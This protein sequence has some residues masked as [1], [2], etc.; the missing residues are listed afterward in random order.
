MRAV[1]TSNV[2]RAFAIGAV[3]L[4]HTT[5][6][7][8]GGGLNLLFLL[9]GMAFAELVFAR[10]EKPAWEIGRDFVARLLLGS[11]FLCLFWFAY[12]RTFEP[13]ELLMFS[14]WITVE[15][16]PLFP[17]WF[18]QT[19]LQ[20]M[21][22]VV[23]LFSVSELRVLANRRP[24]LFS[25]A[26]LAVCAGL[27]TVSKLTF[28]TA[29]LDDR[30][31]HLHAWNFVLGWLFWAV[32]LA[33]EPTARDR[34]AL[35]CVSIALVILVFPILQ[36][37]NWEPRVF[38]FTVPLIFLIWSRELQL[39]RW[40]A[41]P[42]LL[43]SQATLMIFFLHLPVFRAV[44]SML[45]AAFGDVPAALQFVPFAGALIGPVII[46][47]AVTAAVRVWRR[48]ARASLA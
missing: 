20:I 29:A 43:V 27:V 5:L 30:L 19:F 24:V 13:A 41:H 10:T 35:T 9:S 33:R 31:P 4:N 36:L 47:A 22:V 45:R 39:P 26:A 18:T 34:I 7:G 37:K 17:L 25:G 48:N 16:V 15:R 8:L 3:V 40:I 23:A 28:D 11:L 21:I 44:R 1:D 46:W 32:L 42:V 38:V 2:V 6:L 12:Y 14:N